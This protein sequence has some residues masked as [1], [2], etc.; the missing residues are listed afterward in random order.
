MGPSGSSRYGRDD[1]S[2]RGPAEAIVHGASLRVA[3]R[4]T[5]AQAAH[6]AH[7]AFNLGSRFGS[8]GGAIRSPART[9]L[10]LYPAPQ[11]VD[12]GFR[13]RGPSDGLLGV[14]RGIYAGSWM[15]LSENSPTKQLGE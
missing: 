3:R 7:A 13:S 9:I 8:R 15:P 10:H 1:L 4:H 5:L 11:H 6:D 14:L 2:P 12:L